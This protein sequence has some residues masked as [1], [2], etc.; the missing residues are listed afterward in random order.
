MSNQK[1]KNSQTWNLDHK[2]SSKSLP[3]GEKFL[4]S[5]EI[6]KMAVNKSIRSQHFVFSKP[7]DRYSQ[8]E[9]WWWWWL[10][11]NST[12]ILIRRDLFHQIFYW[13]WISFF[14]LRN[15]SSKFDYDRASQKLHLSKF[16]WN[17]RPLLNKVKLSIKILRIKFYKRISWQ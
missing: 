14:L 11:R 5:S 13:I 15:L 10:E 9:W 8:S 7:P 16:F 6:R 2:I 17:L 1:T 4:E 3:S 12:S